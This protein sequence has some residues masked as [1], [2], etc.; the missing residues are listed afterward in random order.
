MYAVIATGGKQYNVEKGSIL[1]VEKLEGNVGDKITLDQVLCVGGEGDIKV[2]KPTLSG[3]SV[4][5]TI[6]EQ[7]RAAKI[8]VFKKKRR[9]GYQKKRGHRQSYT[10][11][12]VEDIKA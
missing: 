12:K 5:C 6:T 7:D 11:L 8:I 2:G 4:I 3:A 1:K 9:K 10:S